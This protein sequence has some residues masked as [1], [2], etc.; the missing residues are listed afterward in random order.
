[1]VSRYY[2]IILISYE[3]WVNFP[4]PEEKK[5]VGKSLVI[6]EKQLM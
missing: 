3:L 5:I 4:C 2:H 6:H 1:M